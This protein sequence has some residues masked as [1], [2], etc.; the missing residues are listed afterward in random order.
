M[1]RLF[2]SAL[3]ISMLAVS[4]QAGVSGM[5]QFPT[6]TYPSPTTDM[7]T[8]GCKNRILPCQ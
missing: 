6:L 4:A 3:L 2:G 7:P 8:V 1:I 5:P